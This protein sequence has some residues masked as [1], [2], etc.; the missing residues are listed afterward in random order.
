M[1]YVHSTQS[2]G[3]KDIVSAKVLTE[4]FFGGG[5]AGKGDEKLL[6][7]KSPSQSPTA[8]QLYS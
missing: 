2:Y 8:T 6:E 7:R 4:E 3:D 5:S 1:N